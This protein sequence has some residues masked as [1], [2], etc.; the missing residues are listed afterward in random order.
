MLPPVVEQVLPQQDISK[1]RLPQL[2]QPLQG[3]G[4]LPIGKGILLPLALQLRDF[5]LQQGD[6]IG[7]LSA[8]RRRA[9][10]IFLR[11]LGKFE[12]G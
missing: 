5:S 7:L 2:F 11:P 3:G 8:L 12:T 9:V 1:L 10:P 4:Q 6:A